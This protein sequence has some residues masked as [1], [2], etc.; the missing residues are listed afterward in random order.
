MMEQNEQI[1][2][3]ASKIDKAVEG[4]NIFEASQ[5][6]RSALLGGGPDGISVDEITDLS[7][8]SA[9]WAFDYHVSVKE[10]GDRLRAVVEPSF[11]G[12][13]GEAHPPE[14]A[15]T[16]DEVVEAWSTLTSVVKSSWALARLHHLLF[17]R[18]H[19][20]PHRHAVSSAENYLKAAMS[21]D[22]G[23]DRT[24]C[25]GVALRIARAVNS[26]DLA[27]SI[28]SQILDD[29][30]HE[31]ERRTARPGVFL[32]LIQPI[33][34]ER[35]P[36]AAID[37]LLEDAGQ[38]YREPFIRDEV[39]LLQIGRAADEV[40][41]RLLWERLVSVWTEA[42]ENSEGLIRA[43]N[44]KKALERAEESQERDLVERATAKLQ[45][46]RKEE[47]GLVA[48]AASMALDQARIGKMLAPIQEV[49][50][51]Q[52]ALLC[53]Y[54][55]Y[56]P[57][58]GNSE[59]NRAQVEENAR[60]FVFST[61]ISREL[62]GGDGLPRY[63]PQ[64]DVDHRSMALAEQETH[65]V[66][67][68]APILAMALSRVA[69]VYGIPSEEELQE[70]FAQAQL[71][72]ESLARA[73]ARS[74]IRY[75]LGDAEGAALTII[76]RIETL[77]RNLVLALDH[78]VYRLQRDQKPGQYPGLGYL[79]DVLKEHGMDESWHRCVL[80]V[81]ANPVGGWNIRNE[82]AHGFIDD[83]TAPTAAVVL[84]IALYMWS[85]RP[86]QS[87]PEAQEGE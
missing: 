39:L 32:R 82:V 38:K 56:G 49:G 1:Q 66:Q 36:P 86:G 71:K 26:S 30:R 9:L 61:L 5:A 79:L 8:K 10:E 21:W 68:W 48:F 6:L 43:A 81:C 73:L 65:R 18:R 72:D 11:R 17:E 75:W 22:I 34:K 77:A 3:L 12:P 74:F 35:R 29:A 24:E 19:G 62:L 52:H 23:L 44:L 46:M 67:M 20:S 25:L 4:K 14:V 80:T 37:E 15:R 58:T 41:R 47:L 70:F 54:Q 83:V 16:P 51:W 7:V 60:Q 64:R 78:G 40:T 87:A 84:Q 27:G 76:P 42:A 50:N 33:L 2:D 31:L 85:L 45:G 59:Q 53:L 69:E 13:S 28:A 63:Q 55:V 57:S